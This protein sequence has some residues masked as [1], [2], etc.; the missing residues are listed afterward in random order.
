MNLEKVDL[1]MLGTCKKVAFETLT[2]IDM[3]A[4]SMN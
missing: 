4:L 3:V 1:S 2:D